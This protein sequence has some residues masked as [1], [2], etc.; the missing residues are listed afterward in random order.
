MKPLEKP[1]SLALLMLTAQAFGETQ[2]NTGGDQDRYNISL[3]TACAIPAAAIALMF[4]CICRPCSWGD[5]MD[6]LHAAV[7]NNAFWAKHEKT[8]EEAL[9]ENGNAISNRPT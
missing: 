7:T 8:T 9:L 2:S 4:I 3:A 5:T 6:C 1:I